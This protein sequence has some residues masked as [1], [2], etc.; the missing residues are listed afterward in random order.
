[1]FQPSDG[2]TAVPPLSADHTPRREPLRLIAFGSLAVV[3]ITIK[4]L[5]KRGYAEP[6]DW[7]TPMP[8]GRG[9]E[10]MA[11]LTK[12]LLLE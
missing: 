10:V 12:H 1:M 3:Q 7:S 9:S 2:G 8:T 5:H 6:N 4:I 11:I